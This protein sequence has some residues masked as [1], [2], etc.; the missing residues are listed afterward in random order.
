MNQEYQI[1][2]QVTYLEAPDIIVMK[3][4]GKVTQQE[5]SEINRRHL[6]MGRDADRLFYLIDMSEFEGMDPELRRGFSAPIYP[7]LEQRFMIEYPQLNK[8]A[9]LEAQKY[10]SPLLNPPGYSDIE[11]KLTEG[12]TDV[13]EGRKNARQMV[14]ELAPS[15][16]EMIKNASKS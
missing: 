13:Y 11:K 3:L 10:A 15:I 12:I 4:F 14:T 1:G 8:A 5:G 2:R 9:V 7:G 6:E 16:N